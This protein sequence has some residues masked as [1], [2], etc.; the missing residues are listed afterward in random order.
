[1]ADRLA[2]IVGGI[3]SRDPRTW[4]DDTRHDRSITTRLGWLDVAGQ[5]QRT[6]GDLTAFADEVRSAGFTHAL[7]LGMGGSSLAPEV[8]R[9]TYGVRDG[10]LDLAVLDSTDPATILDLERRLPAE[11]TLYVVSTKSGTTTETLSFQRYFWQRTVDAVGRERAGRQFIAITDPGSALEKDARGH[12]Y[13]RVFL[14]PEDIGGR[15]SALSYFGLVPAA[16]IGVDL[17]RLLDRA[18]AARAACA[19]EAPVGENPA[20]MLGEAMARHAV[21][22]RDKVTLICSPQFQT[23]G[24]WVEQLIAESSGKEEKGI[25]RIEGAALGEAGVYGNDRLFVTVGV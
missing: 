11:K 1:M 6:A 3:W 7:L 5:M 8:L 19:A 2:E 20:A 21:A 23:F 9:R 22:G 12:T 24:Y 13:R 25:V 14:N 15:Y 17:G 16:L 18:E 4:S 10:F